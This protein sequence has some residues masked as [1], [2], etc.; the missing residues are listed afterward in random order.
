LSGGVRTEYVGTGQAL[1]YDPVDVVWTKRLLERKNTV[2]N[3]PKA[4]SRKP[5]IVVKD[6]G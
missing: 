4:E 1:T 2:E 3:L 5:S 6:N